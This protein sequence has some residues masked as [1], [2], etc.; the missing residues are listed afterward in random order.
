MSKGIVGHAS[1][2]FVAFAVTAFMSACG[3]CAPSP[4][5][6]VSPPAPTPAPTTP[7]PPVTPISVTVYN[8]LVEAGCM[9]P[10]DGGPLAIT[11][12]WAS[13]VHDPWLA[14][15]Y[16]GGTVQACQACGPST[17]LKRHR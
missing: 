7:P 15:L 2:L 1:V 16:D 4:P 12:Q 13:D 17:T 8:E 5:S 9:D 3:S 6:P 14:C 10:D 11:E